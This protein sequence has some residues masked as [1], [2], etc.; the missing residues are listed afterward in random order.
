M[1]NSIICGVSFLAGAIVGS[2]A[3]YKYIKDKYE[4]IAQG[5]INSIKEAYKRKIGEN[6]NISDEKST[7]KVNEVNSVKDHERIKDSIIYDNIIKKNE[8]THYSDIS[9]RDECCKDFDLPYIISPNDYGELDEYETI[10][11]TYYSDNVLTDEDDTIIPNPEE[12]VGRGFETHFGEY[13]D[14]AVYVRNSERKIDFE[15]LKDFRTY[16][17]VVK[18]KPHLEV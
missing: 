12:F 10:S 17:E 7:E 11:L 1:K 4:E 3:T 5:E 13:E 15:I 16:T 2:Y 6:D 14:D 8:Y 9:K 18:E